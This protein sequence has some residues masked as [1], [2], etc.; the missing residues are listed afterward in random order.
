MDATLSPSTRFAAWWAKLPEALRDSYRAGPT[1]MAAHAGWVAATEDRNMTANIPTAED[2]AHCARE[3]LIDDICHRRAVEPAD[4]AAEFNAA[5]NYV[6]AWAL[7]G[8][9]AADAFVEYCTA[10]DADRARRGA[11]AASLRRW[12]RDN[13]EWV[14]AE[15]RAAIE[16][17]ADRNSDP[18]AWAQ[19][20]VYLEVSP[21]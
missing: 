2:F 18:K 5:H 17:Y 19:Y 1:I 9:T 10:V 3:S 8:R 6:P 12:M 20:A 4:W 7:D 11:L 21:L 13:G 14:D 16:A 15:M